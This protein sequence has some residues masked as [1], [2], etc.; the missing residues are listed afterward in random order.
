MKNG[1]TL[2]L[3]LSTYFAIKVLQLMIVDV[4]NGSQLVCYRGTKA[5][6]GF[7]QT[8]AHSGHIGTVDWL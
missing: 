8:R 6:S 5:G 1:I 3:A 4:I 7:Y 2:A